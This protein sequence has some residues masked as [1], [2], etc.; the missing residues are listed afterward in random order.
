[1]KHHLKHCSSQIGLLDYEVNAKEPF[2]SDALRF[3]IDIDDNWVVCGRRSER[4]DEWR[5]LADGAK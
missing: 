2:L 3:D 4:S 1:M 5:A